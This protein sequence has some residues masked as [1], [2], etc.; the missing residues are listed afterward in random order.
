MLHLAIISRPATTI[1]AR[2]NSIEYGFTQS[3]GQILAYGERTY[4]EVGF[5]AREVLSPGAVTKQA[6]FTSYRVFNLWRRSN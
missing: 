4:Q 3:A 1:G 5:I 2:A 6:S